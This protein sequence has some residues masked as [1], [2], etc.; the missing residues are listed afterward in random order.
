M[1]CHA[2]GP[3]LVRLSIMVLAPPPRELPTHTRPVVG[4]GRTRT[5]FCVKRAHVRI[6][7]MQ[8]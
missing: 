6:M 3:A 5:T 1:G 8:I 7:W 4:E 2:L